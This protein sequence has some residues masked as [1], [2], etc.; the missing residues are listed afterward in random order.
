MVTKK[1]LEEMLVRPAGPTTRRYGHLVPCLKELYQLGLTIKDLEAL[2]PVSRKWI[3][4][5]FGEDFE[6]RGP[7]LREKFPTADQVLRV[8]KKHGLTLEK[9]S[10]MPKTPTGRKKKKKT[11]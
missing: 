11:R 2:F 7:G 9:L 4:A 6:Y 5:Q 8:L 10:R 3:R 1:E